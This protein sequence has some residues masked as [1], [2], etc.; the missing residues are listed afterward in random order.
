MHKENMQTIHRK[1]EIE[2]R[3]CLVGGYAASHNCATPQYDKNQNSRAV[4]LFKGK[5]W[6]VQNITEGTLF[7][8]TDKWDS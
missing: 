8:K 4:L 5:R 3:S 2:P 1:V 7:A 6:D